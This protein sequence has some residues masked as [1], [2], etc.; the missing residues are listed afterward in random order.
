MTRDKDAAVDRG[1][2]IPAWFTTAA[3]ILP[4]GIL[5]QFLSAGLGMF[6]DSNFL[7]QHKMIGLGLSAAPLILLIASLAIRHLRPFAGWASLTVLL[8]II[9]IMLAAEAVPLLLAFHPINGSL[10]LIVSLIFLKKLSD[11]SSG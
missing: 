5:V 1:H 10:L 2:T 11:A 4:A 6:S 8:Y 7:A 3:W 9:Q